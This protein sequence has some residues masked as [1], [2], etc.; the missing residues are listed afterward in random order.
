MTYLLFIVL[1]LFLMI[2]SAKTGTPIDDTTWLCLAI[3]TAG[4]M[5]SWRKK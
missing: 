3:L 4:E 2:W 1:S 5:I